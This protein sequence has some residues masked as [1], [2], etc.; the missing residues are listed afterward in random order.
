MATKIIQGILLDAA[1]VPLSLATIRF[2]ATST[3]SIV[4]SITTDYLTDSLGNYNISLEHGVYT[5]QIKRQDEVGFRT[6]C[7]NAYIASAGVS[8]IEAIIKEQ[9]FIQ[10]VNDTIIAEMQAVLAQTNSAAAL[11]TTKADSATTSAATASNAAATATTKA[12]AAAT[13]AAT[14]TTKANEASTSAANAATSA[15]TATTKANEA[16]TSATTATTKATEASTS[17]ANA[18]A[19]A[20]TATTKA[21]EASTSA[22]N[23]ATS[24]TTATTKATEASTSAA[25]AAATISQVTNKATEAAVSA[26]SA[27]AAAQEAATSAALA[28]G[29]LIEAGSVDLSSGTY[30]TPIK[31]SLGNNRSCFWKVTVGGVVGVDT[32]GIGDSLV[33]SKEI[34]GY[35]KIDNTESVSSVN[36]KQGV[37]VLSKGD[38]GLSLVNNTS[39][40]NKPVSLATQTAL[41]SKAPISHVGSV[42]ESAHGL[43]SQTSAGFMGPADKVKLDNMSVTLGV[44]SVNEKTGAVVLTKEDLGLGLVNNTSDLDKPISTATQI[45]LATKYSP[46][47]KPTAADIGALAATG[48]AVAATKLATARTIAGKSFDGTANISITAADVGLSNVDNTSDINKPIS[49]AQQSALNLKANLASPALTG[50]PS[51]P[52]AAVGTSTTQIATTAFVNAEIANDAA[53]KSH[54]GATGTAH[55]V[56]STSVAGFMSATDKTKLDGIATG[57]NAY[58]HPTSGVTSGTYNSVTVDEN[59]HITAGTNP[60]TLAGYGITDAAPKSHSHSYL[61]LT[62]GT[63]TGSLSISPAGHAALE[64][65]RTDGVASTPFIDFHA[66]AT[67]VDYDARVVALSGTGVSGGGTLQVVAGN[68]TM[69]KATIT[70]IVGTT[71]SAT[72]FSGDVSGNAS[73][74]SK[75]DTARTLTFTGGSTGT[76]SIDGSGNVSI[77]MTVPPTGHVHALSTISDSPYKEA[78]D[79]ATTAA[80]TVTATTTTLTNSGTLAA[81]VLDGVTCTDGMRVL[82]KNQ[83]STAQNGIYTVT[84]AGSASVAWVLTRAADADTAAEIAGAVVTV[85]QGTVNGAGLFT[86][87]FK[88]TS[89][90]GTTGMQWRTVV[91]SGNISS[92][93][94]TSGVTAGTYRSVTVNNRGH[95]T[96]GT[97][98]TTLDGYGITD[99][100]Q[101]ASAAGLDANA[102]TNSALFKLGGAGWANIPSGATGNGDH[103]LNAHWDTNAGTQLYLPYNKS[104]VLAWR[105][106][107]SG[108]YSEWMKLY[109]EGNKPTAADV[110]AAPSSHVGA[111]GTAHG[112]ATTSVAGFMSAADKTKLDGLGSGASAD[113]LTTPRSINGTSFDGT[114]DIVT[115]NWG[116]SRTISIGGTAKTV[117]GSS[118]VSW[119]TSELGCL[120]LTGGTLSGSLLV[121]GSISSGTSGYPQLYCNMNVT[122]SI[123]TITAGPGIKTGFQVKKGSST[124]F[125]VDESGELFAKGVHRVYHTDNKPTATDVGLGNVNNTSDLNKPISTAT[126]AALDGKSATT[127]TH[128][129]ADVGALSTSG[130]SLSGDLNTYGVIKLT[131]TTATEGLCNSFGRNIVRGSNQAVNVFGNE[132]DAMYFDGNSLTAWQVRYNG[133]L[134]NIYHTGNKPTPA[135]IGLGNVN[136]TSD[137]NKPISTATQTALN[138]KSATTHTHTAADVGALAATGTAAAATKLATARTIAGKS[139]D[140]TANISITAAD[141]GALSTGGGTLSGDLNTSGTIKFT[142]S[143]S[144]GLLNSFGRSIARGSTV[145]VNVFG[146]TS[147]AMYFDGD[148]LTAWQ[149]RYNGTLYNIYHTG[150]KPTPAEIGAQPATSDIRVK[151]NITSLPPVL[152]KIMLIDPKTFT[153]EGREGTCVGTIAQDWEVDFPEVILN[154]PSTSQG[155]PEMLKGIDALGTIGILLKAIQELKAEVEELKNR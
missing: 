141:V 2:V 77:A 51:A 74:A 21:N 44:S 148:S 108:S 10:E 155:E 67:A 94:N 124:Y 13:S 99:A 22:A 132:T 105:R 58:T 46:T 97:N 96:A 89:T 25:N 130:G 18:A 135:E 102:F 35:Y 150:N 26:Q 136:N 31:D 9:S 7:A 121:Q 33:Y 85:D 140:G 149:V 40:I 84:N 56:A 70:D 81:L 6:V 111:T 68:V 1:K 12:T 134:Y 80:L 30:P 137:L 129:A 126:Q 5:I 65:G 63:L 37:V 28:A 55:G 73:T 87:D 106:K 64:I 128:T 125:L 93:H 54:V 145:A 60:T 142:N 29:A 53:P 8:T 107:S 78:A 115:A 66:G 147:D 114:S 71:V 138:G 109:H 92:L 117:D 50:T 122:D 120:P 11:A 144:S 49:T 24:A 113:K 47:N 41:D 153:M 17:A 118:D 152:D 91:D 143:S 75:W 79:V 61:P 101:N 3:R 133:T 119:S 127:H 23:A 36:G 103:V 146:N 43:V 15:T 151:S 76:G 20:T 88:K 112:L 45:A 42:G 110:G 82:V 27:L 98:P 116:T 52:T 39:D 38:L 123:A 90:L 154:V 100:L 48:T 72:T 139:F 83:T 57:A 104:T 59:G 32:Y 34:S 4:N 19:S 69:S 95:V 131:N 62:G 86:N 14:A 16:S